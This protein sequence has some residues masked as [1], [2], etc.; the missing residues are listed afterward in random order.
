MELFI[1]LDKKEYPITKLI[2]EHP[3]MTKLLCKID[4]HT[5]GEAFMCTNLSHTMFFLAV[6]IRNY[7]REL[8]R[9]KYIESRKANRRKGGRPK[10]DAL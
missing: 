10:K 6:Q 8:K 9:D 1:E 4:K 3:F 2:Y 5:I 7:F